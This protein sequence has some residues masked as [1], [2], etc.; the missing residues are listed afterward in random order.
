M[1]KI[2][3]YFSEICGF[4]RQKRGG[5][6]GGGGRSNSQGENRKADLLC[7]SELLGKFFNLAQCL[8]GLM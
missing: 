7:I 4:W 8:S 1:F 3:A 6:G 5:G 2:D